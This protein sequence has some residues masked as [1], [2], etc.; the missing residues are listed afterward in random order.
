VNGT[1]TQNVTLPITKKGTLTGEVW[2]SIYMHAADGAYTISDLTFVP[3]G[4]PT[5]VWEPAISAS[6]TFQ[7]DGE[8][9]GNTGIKRDS[10]AGEIAFGVIDGGFTVTLTDGQYKQFCV[11]V[12]TGVGG[13]DYY[14]TAWAPACATGTN[15]TVTFMASVVSG[16]GQIRI[17]PN[18]N[19]PDWPKSQ[20]LTTT[21]TEVTYSWTQGSGNLKFDTGNSAVGTVITITGIKVTTP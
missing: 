1:N 15:Y 21:P 19:S 7:G 2:F 14:Y 4:A 11:Q 8:Y 16:T 12:G 17:G 6:T 5:I 9:I 10:G 3:V 18:N 20:D 13:T